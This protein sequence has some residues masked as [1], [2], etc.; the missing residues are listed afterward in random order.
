M[1]NGQSM[2]MNRLVELLHD[3]GATLVVE[4][5]GE[6]MTFANRGVKDLF[7]LYTNHRELL[8][9]ARVADKVTGAGAAALMALGGVA[10]YHTDV[11][12]EKALSLLDRAGVAGTAEKVVPYI[13][14][15]AGTG[16]CPLESLIGDID[17]LEEI[18]DVI[19]GFIAGLTM[20]V[21][22]RAVNR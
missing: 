3:S 6:V 13:I 14:N 5:R 22:G 20:N 18:Y 15:R 7:E 2:D 11:I 1:H 21:N 12:S 8:Q 10:E 16:Q 4:S 9:G 19:V 17:N